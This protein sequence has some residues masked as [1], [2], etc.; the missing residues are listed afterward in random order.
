MNVPGLFAIGGAFLVA[1]GCFAYLFGSF[2][3]GLFSKV[4]QEDE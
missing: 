1:F 2:L 3:I 4:P